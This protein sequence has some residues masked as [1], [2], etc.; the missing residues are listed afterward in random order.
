[1]NKILTVNRP[2][3][4]DDMRKELAEIVGKQVNEWCNNEVDLE[5]CIESAYEILEYNSIGNGFERAKEFEKH[6]FEPDA[7]LVEILDDTSY[8]R[9]KVEET[10][11]KN[12]VKENNLKLELIEGQ[13]VV[14]KI[15]RKGD[16]ECEIVKLYH[17]TMQ[18]GV[19]HEGFEYS[20]GKG[21]I[22]IDFERIVSVL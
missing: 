1:M 3:W 6:G 15:F 9:T 12:W 16:V 5:E 2:T 20:K 11:V 18:Y 7:E 17:E 19:W 8:N 22:I 13:K 14:T 21:C 10:F 4:G